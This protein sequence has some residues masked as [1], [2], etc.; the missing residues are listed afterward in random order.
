MS[1][2]WL[3]KLNSFVPSWVLEDQGIDK[4]KILSVFNAA[5]AALQRAEDSGNA[6]LDETYISTATE[7][8]LLKHGSERSI[9]RLKDEKLS[10][11]RER[12]KLIVNNSNLPALVDLIQP[13]LIQGVPTMI[14]HHSATGGFLNRGSYANRNIIDFNVLYN[15]FTIIIDEQIPDPELFA[16][17]SNFLNREEFIGSDKS[18]DSIFE[19]IVKTVN[20]NKA[21]GTVYRLIERN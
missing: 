18:I 17:R 10:S 6:T 4:Q 19:N 5:A 11:Y 20:N 1:E 3:K 8:N 13:M 12:V 21:Y 14:E 7:D 2:K 9:E 16:N 15:A